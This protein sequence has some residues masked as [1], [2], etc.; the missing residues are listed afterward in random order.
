MP[1]VS[2]TLSAPVAAAILTAV[3]G[4]APAWAEDFPLSS[5]VTAATVYAG[6]GATLVREAGFDLPAGHHRLILTDLPFLDMNSLRVSAPGLVLGTVSYREEAVPPSGR[7]EDPRITA[8]REAVTAV[9]AELQ[10]IEDRARSA[11]LAGEAARDRIAFLSRM[12]G[13]EATAA[14]APDQIGALLDLV[15]QEGLAA[16]QAAQTAEVEARGIREGRAPVEKRLKEAQAALD[17]LLT[18]RQETTVLTV[19]VTAESAVSG[20][21]AVSYASNAAGWQ[22]AYDLQLT[23]GDAPA[24]EVTRT[25]QVAQWTGEDWTDVAVSFS[26]GRPSDQL[27]PSEMMGERLQ[28]QDPGQPMMT[29]RAQSDMKMT[30]EAA[31]MP[32]MPVMAEAAMASSDGITVTYAAPRPV[33]LANGVEGGTVELDRLS[34]SPDIFARAVPRYDSSAF[35]V[36][37]VTNDSGE[38]LVSGPAQLYRD[39]AYVGATHLGLLPEGETVDWSFGPIDGLRVSRVLDER[40]EG[41]RGVINRTNQRQEAVT[42]KVENRTP[43]DWD[44]RLLDGVPYSEQEDLKVTWTADPMPEVQDYDDRKGVL[45]WQFP[46]AAGADREIRLDHTVTWPQDKQLR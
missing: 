11:E 44:I 39:G 30:L 36:A 5:A 21:L 22:P 45:E 43:L 15:G 18:A 12:A 32:E 27:A 28:I 4:A 17:A 9:E 42:L 35:L 23:T 38:I 25:A 24:L 14:M 2:M 41:D 7:E 40:M 16:R 37:S 8:A 34:L 29:A 10:Q 6:S 20:T 33:T 3:L 1:R 31:P 13:G 46:L 19:E 26:T